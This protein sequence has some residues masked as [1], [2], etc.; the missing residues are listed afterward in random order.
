MSFTFLA[1]DPDTGNTGSPTLWIDE[2][3]GDLIIQAY[4]ADGATLDE[5]RRVGSVA[6]HSVD[7]P[8]GETIVRLPARMIPLLPRS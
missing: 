1:I 4:R 7:V 3:T 2:Q 8:E 6:G 5:C